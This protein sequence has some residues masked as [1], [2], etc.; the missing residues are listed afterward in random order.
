MTAY[1]TNARVELRD[2]A[3]GLSHRYAGQNA[4]DILRSAIERDFPGRIGLVSSFGTDAAVL[5]HM[6]SRIDPYVPVI[7]L[8]TWKHFPETLA[9]R[10][11]LI[12]HLGLCNIQTVTPRQPGVE[13]D[14]PDGT[15]HKTNPDLCCH[16]RKSLPMLAALRS[17]DCWITGRK[18]Q[19]ASTR[20][21]MDLFETQDR[22]LKVNPLCDWGR[23]ETE[24][25]FAEHALPEHP[26]KPQGYLSVGCAPCTRAVKPG[27]DARAGR[28]AESD[29]VECGIHFENGKIVRASAKGQTS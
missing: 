13:A 19:Q 28:W 4:A 1:E 3:H 15:L 24:A 14:D 21:T 8:D 6:V 27:E 12:E 23:A 16:V 2:R 9:Y 26:L 29:K 18:R 25:Y 10:D 5:L 20:T 22:W 17:L 7:F 11:T